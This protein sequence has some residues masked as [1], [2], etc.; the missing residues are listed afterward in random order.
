MTFNKYERAIT[1]EKTANLL[2]GKFDF[3][4]IVLSMN[5]NLGNMA[6]K[7]QQGSE[8]KRETEGEIETI[9][10]V[11]TQAPLHFVR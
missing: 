10:D 8:D 11:N 6:S 7:C 5:I 1:G 2:F 9:T 3:L 4:Q